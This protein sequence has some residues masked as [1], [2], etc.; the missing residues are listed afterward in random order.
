LGASRSSWISTRTADIDLIVG[1]ADRPYN[2]IYLFRNIGTATQPL[3]DRAEWLGPGKKDL[4]AADFNG[5]GHV[6]LV[7][8]GGY[9][10]DVK[11]NRLS[12]F[13]P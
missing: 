10:N 13:V 9:Y 1:C 6:D 8:S 3:F 12:K 4:V 5:D 7:I 11:R 2:G